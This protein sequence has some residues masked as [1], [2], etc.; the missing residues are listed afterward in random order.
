MK[1][2]LPAILW[3]VFATSAASLAYPVVQPHIVALVGQ[4]RIDAAYLIQESAQPIAATWPN[5]DQL[6]ADCEAAGFRLQFADPDVQD[7]IGG[8]TPAKL[9]PVLECAREH[10]LPCVVLVRNG[11]CKAYD[12]PATD[13]GIRKLLGVAR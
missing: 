10:G 11:K 5:D 7:R 1:R 9:V 3:C 2:F 4:S 6:R 8:S 13:A 12:P